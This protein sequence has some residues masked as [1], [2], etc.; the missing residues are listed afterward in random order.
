MA[1]EDT[2]RSTQIRPANSFTIEKGSNTCMVKNPVRQPDHI[3]I[4]GGEKWVLSLPQNELREVHDRRSLDKEFHTV[5]AEKEKERL[6]SAD[7]TSGTAR[8]PA[9]EDIVKT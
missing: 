2:S 8:R 5:G 6:A 7:R 9:K 4:Y 3:K 1:Y